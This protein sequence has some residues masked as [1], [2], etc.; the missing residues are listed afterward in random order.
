MKLLIEKMEKYLDQHAQL[1]KLKEP[2]VKRSSGGAARYMKNALESIADKVEILSTD[3]WGLTPVTAT[4]YGIRIPV[5]VG[6]QDAVN[7]GVDMYVQFQSPLSRG[8][9]N[10]LEIWPSIYDGMKAKSGL[11]KKL[12]KINLSKEN[13]W[14]SLWVHVD[15]DGK[16]SALKA[17]PNLVHKLGLSVVQQLLRNEKD[18]V[19]FLDTE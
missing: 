6:V 7:G 1:S 10:W 3:G 13:K 2:D 19:E 16:D 4:M 8:R 9:Q 14:P 15:A 17:F 12:G 18:F 5:H 11:F